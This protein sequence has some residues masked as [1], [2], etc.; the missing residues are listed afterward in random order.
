MAPDPEDVVKGEMMTWRDLALI[1]LGAAGGQAFAAVNT[2]GP[3]NAIIGPAVAAFA[4]KKGKTA[5]VKNIA[6]G[7]GVGAFVQGLSGLYRR[8]VTKGVEEFVRGF[9]KGKPSI[10]MAV[11]QGLLDILT[12]KFGE[13][14]K[15][16]KKEEEKKETKH[17]VEIDKEIVVSV[18]PVAQ[19]EEEEEKKEISQKYE[20][21]L[22]VPAGA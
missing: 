9:T 18:K 6:I 19:K 8:T 16:E 10:G 3:I 13:A 1:F 5:T 21:E 20:E 11:E 2:L 14:K 12:P 7:F 15:E 4:V 17:S 22:W